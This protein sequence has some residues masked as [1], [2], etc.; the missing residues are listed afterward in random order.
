MST[1]SPVGLVLCDGITMIPDGQWTWDEEFSTGYKPIVYKGAGVIFHPELSFGTAAARVNKPLTSKTVAYWEIKVPHP[2]FGTSIMFGVGTKDARTTLPISFND[3]LGEDDCSIG[4]NHHGKLLLSGDKYD[5]CNPLSSGKP[6]GITLGILFNGPQ[7]SISFFNEG[8][9]LGT[10]SLKL[11]LSQTYY[12]M[13]ASTAQRSQFI[14]TRQ[15]VAAPTC[16]TL[17]ESAVRR[18]ASMVVCDGAVEVLPIPVCIKSAL[19]QQMHISRIH[20]GYFSY[21][22]ECVL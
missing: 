1:S 6:E 3:L 17:F 21:N 19:Y 16:P 2:L 18:V 13:V 8:F 9:K 7:A 10:A 11:D 15:L 4:L 12:P 20:S 14:I 22:S 5:F